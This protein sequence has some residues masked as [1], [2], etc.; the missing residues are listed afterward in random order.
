MPDIVYGLTGM[1]ISH[2]IELP[3]VA[4]AARTARPDAC[5]LC[6]SDRSR[7]WALAQQGAGESDDTAELALPQAVRSLL[8]G[9]PIER[10]SAAHALGTPESPAPL[11]PRAGL[12][13]DSMLH[14]DYPAVRAIAW[15]ALRRLWNGTPPP[16]NA[17]T[18]TD[19]KA[20][21]E[22]AIAGIRAHLSQAA[23]A[24]DAGLTARLREQAAA[25]A[26]HIGE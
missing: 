20:A 23:E 5:T 21:R 6:H 16:S 7:A 4:A 3:D 13:L 8:A 11:P 10:A 14:D 12:L 18:A 9:D 2:R 1:R 25:V 19:T 17:F 26:I 24:P 15:S 22:K